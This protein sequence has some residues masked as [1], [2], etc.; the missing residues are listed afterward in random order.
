MYEILKELTSGT[1]LACSDTDGRICVLK[2]ID[3]S[4]LPLYK[5]FAKASGKYIAS[6]YETTAFG[7]EIYAVFEYVEG[8]TLDAYIKN[9]GVLSESEA[10]RFT[11]ELCEGLNL[12]H[13]L[14][15]VHRDINPANIII[16]PQGSVKIIDFGIMRL[17]KPGRSSDTQLLGTPAFAAP[18]QY[19]FGQ[20]SPKSD[21]YALGVLINYM[22]TGCTPGEKT[23]AGRFANIIIKCTQLDEANR[24]N[25][26]IE[27]KNAVKRHAAINTAIRQ[28]PGFRKSNTLHKTVAGIYYAGALLFTALM[29]CG[30]ESAAE[31]FRWL[32]VCVFS[33]FVPVFIIFD[34]KNYLEKFKLTKNA[35][36]G[37][38]IAF[39]AVLTLL[40]L[41]AALAAAAA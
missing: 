22:L 21:I 30:N 40:S 38:K 7:G 3:V 9:H 37:G 34:Y 26:V 2:K 24:Y 8:V 36:V 41:A 11:I 29:M 25:N 10:A 27:V 32:I 1:K 28:I 31:T 15:I 35:T 17:E 39:K 6:L 5:K 14:G 23:A 33:L 4:D 12:L 18:E 20:S 19:G 16:T 13:G